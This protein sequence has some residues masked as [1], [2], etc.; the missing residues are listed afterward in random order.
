MRARLLFFYLFFV[1][2]SS[3]SQKVG[4]YSE[5]LVPF[6][7]KGEYG[8]L[9]TKGR[10]IIPFEYDTVYK[11]FR[12]GFAIVGKDKKAGVIDRKGKVIIPFEFLSIGEYKNKLIPVENEKGLWG[13]YS[14]EGKPLVECLYDNFRIGEKGRLIVQQTGKW[15]AIDIKGNVLLDFN[16]RELSFDG[17]RFE[18]TLINKWTLKNYRNETLALFEY[19][20]VRNSDGKEVFIYSI[21]GNHGL[22]NSKGEPITHAIY[23]YIFKFR[24]GLAIVEKRNEYGIVTT[25][26]KTALPIQYKQILIDSIYI[27]V[28]EKNGKWMLLEKNGTPV[29]KTQYLALGE[30]SDGLMAAM[31]TDSLWGYITTNGKRSTLFRFSKAD[32]FRKGMAEV[33]VYYPAIKKSFR[34]V[35]DKKGEFIIKPDDYEFYKTGLIKISPSLKA[36]YVVPRENYSAYEKLKN[37]MVRVRQGENYGVITTSGKEIIPTIYDYVSP[38]SDDGY[39]IVERDGKSGVIN[40]KG[41]MTL[42]M[43]NKYEKIYG[44]HE[45]L[46]RFLLKGRYGL[47]DTVNNVY[48]SPQY[49]KTGEFSDGLVAV[50]IKDKWGFMDK[51]ERLKV[52]PYYNQVWP[53]KNG[54]AKVMSGNKYTIVNKEGKELHPLFDDIDVTFTGRYLLRDE[55]KYGLADRNGR[56]I[57]APKYD[58]IMELGNGYIKVERNKLLGILDYEATIIIPLENDALFYDATTNTIFTVTEGKKQAV[59]VK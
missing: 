3:F 26:G 51:N 42:K 41:E 31:E 43:T 16:Y 11:G 45:G 32:P 24:D 13:F 4:S 44:F 27:R 47:L 58:H 21:V 20:S 9:D 19:D 18:A 5:G 6:K 56:E 59:S 28:Q 38:P 46:S 34:A 49:P 55:N 39:F 2:L 15:G 54:A 7:N 57:L 10:T 1:T 53:F 22:C 36:S 23:D 12:E 40:S 52:Q 17:Q 14:Y 30:Y 35:I 25:E 33:E 48:I 37:G 50:V 29:L 8:F